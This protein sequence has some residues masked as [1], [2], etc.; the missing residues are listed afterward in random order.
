M[1]NIPENAE[2][3][4]DF[5]DDS[6]DYVWT[7][8]LS[9]ESRWLIHQLDRLMP[10]AVYEYSGMYLLTVGEAMYKLSDPA[11]LDTMLKMLF[12]KEIENRMRNDAGVMTGTWIAGA[13]IVKNA[14]RAFVLGLSGSVPCDAGGVVLLRGSGEFD[15]REMTVTPHFEYLVAI[16]CEIFNAVCEDGEML[17]AKNGT[18]VVL[19][20]E[21]V[22]MVVDHIPAGT[23]EA[24]LFEKRV[25]HTSFISRGVS[26]AMKHVSQI[27]TLRLGD[28]YVPGETLETTDR[29]AAYSLIAPLDQAFIRIPDNALRYGMHLHVHIPCV[30]ELLGMVADFDTGEQWKYD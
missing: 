5:S 19:N 3:L 29:E 16:P 26:G 17:M 25:P 4:T 8:D 18:P 13:T 6:P 7:A 15:A 21:T 23:R 10:I 1:C 14:G 22:L 20:E 24:E 27:P 11:Q 30:S 28:Y 9:P 12:H 2:L